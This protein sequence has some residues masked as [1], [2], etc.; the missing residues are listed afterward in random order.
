MFDLSFRDLALLLGLAV[1]IVYKILFKFP[2]VFGLFLF[3][4]SCS[5]YSPQEEET[6]LGKERVRSSHR[7]PWKQGSWST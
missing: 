4:L 7:T 1:F 5:F 3:L 2:L 6:V